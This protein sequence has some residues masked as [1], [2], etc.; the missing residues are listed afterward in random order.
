LDELATNT[1]ERIG[2]AEDRGWPG[3]VAGLSESLIHITRKK[4][5]ALQLLG[6]EQLSL[7]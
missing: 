4:D 7:A 2:E 6:V 5:Q 1:S 3:E